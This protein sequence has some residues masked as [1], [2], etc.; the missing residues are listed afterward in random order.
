[1]QTNPTGYC[2]K[3]ML[4]NVPLHLTACPKFSIY[5]KGEFLYEV[6]LKYDYYQKYQS[7]T[8]VATE[9]GGPVRILNNSILMINQSV[10]RSEL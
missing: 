2:F 1:M 7:S 8:I 3:Q 6:N 9:R 5:C 4:L 10:W